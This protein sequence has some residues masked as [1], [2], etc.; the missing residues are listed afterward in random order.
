[1]RPTELFIALLLMGTGLA[2]AT[3]AAN[4]VTNAINNFTDTFT[5]SVESIINNALQNLVDFTNFLKAIVM[6]A[7]RVLAVALGII[8][9]FLWLSGIS[10]YRGKRLVVSAVLLSLLVLVVNSL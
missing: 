8:G 6:T 7:S 2:L 3:H 1:M 4:N 10:P 5:R 9:G